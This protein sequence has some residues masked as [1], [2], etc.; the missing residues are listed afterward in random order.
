MAQHIP[1]QRPL[2]KE[3]SN[4]L[5]KPFKERAASKQSQKQDVVQNTPGTCRQAG[6][7]KAN[8]QASGYSAMALSYSFGKMPVYPQSTARI[9]PKLAVNQPGDDHE[10]EADAVA[11]KIVQMSSQPFVRPLSLRAVMQPGQSL[12]RTCAHCEEEEEK[13]SLQRK[14]ADGFS[15]QRKCA[16]CEAEEKEKQLQRKTSGSAGDGTALPAVEQTLQSPGRPMD[17]HTRS[18][19]EQRFGYDFGKVRIHDDGLAHRSSSAIQAKA[20]TYQH[21]VVFGAGQYNPQTPTGQHLLA[22]ELTHVVQQNGNTI[23]RQE[24]DDTLPGGSG[25]GQAAHIVEDNAAPAPGQMR[26]SA[27]LRRLNDEVCTTVDRALQG[28]PYSSNNCPYIRS[29]FA[30]HRSS[31]P[32]QLEQLLLRYEPSAMLAR[33]AEGL[34]Q[35]VLIRVEAAVNRWKRTGDLSH[36]PREIA[37]QIRPHLGAGAPA[38]AGADFSFK[39]NAGGAHAT[40]SPAMALQTLGKG[41]ALDSTSRGRM[42]QAF[43]TSFSHVEIHTD[44]QASTLSG[45]MNARAFTVGNH[46]AFGSGEYKPGT[47]VG[48]ALLAHELAHVV[49][50]GNVKKDEPHAPQGASEASY[51]DDADFSAI[52]A[53]LA[54]WSGFKLGIKDIHKNAMPRLRSGLRLQRCAAPAAGALL[55]GGAETATV[56][57]GGAAVAGGITATDVLVG[58]LVIGTGGLVLEGDSPRPAPAPSASSTAAPTAGTTTAPTPGTTTAPTTTTTPAPATGTSTATTAA[59]A[60]TAAA[61]AELARRIA[62]CE[63]IHRA[64]KALGNCRACRRTDTA[65]ERAAKIACLTAVIAGRRNYLS[66]RCDYILPGSIARGSAIA[67]RGHI[68]QA[69]QLEAMLA[70]CSTLPTR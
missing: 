40:Q 70:N 17:G 52:R 23:Q 16:A 54:A 39:A 41:S 37:A 11:D 56:V 60:A 49:Q 29:A 38:G 1:T 9:Q 62:E 19:M 3:G 2:Q 22:H 14:P 50:Q 7:D 26:K 21:H 8:Q 55:L 43:Q 12:Q 45:N 34:I 46:I 58:G 68:I 4:D 31:S 48:D 25:A 24:M 36:V 59:T 53:V 57:G 61:A 33:D 28:T 69:E 35:I 20:Y 10:K 15:L 30:R 13:P 5:V 47:L 66:K 67:E 42:E 65:A 18:F 32:F 6:D 27:F 63:A 51:E 64:Y 44:N